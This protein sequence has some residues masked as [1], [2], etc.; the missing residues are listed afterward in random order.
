[1][2][3]TIMQLRTESIT[4][5]CTYHVAD[6]YC[7][8]DC[9]EHAQRTQS[10]GL[11]VVNIYGAQYYPS[12]AVSDFSTRVAVILARTVLIILATGENP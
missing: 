8:A 12:G 7:Q 4:L 1:M 9:L 3:I 6:I 11:T 2:L 5:A 10:G